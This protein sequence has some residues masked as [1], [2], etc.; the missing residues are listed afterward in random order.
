MPHIKHFQTLADIRNNYAFL[1]RFEAHQDAMRAEDTAKFER[2]CS[3]E[4][5]KLRFDA[6]LTPEQAFAQARQ[7]SAVFDYLLSVENHLARG[8][9]DA[10]RPDADY[11]IAVFQLWIDRLRD[12]TGAPD[13]RTLARDPFFKKQYEACKH[14][15]FQF[16]L[17]GWVNKMPASVPTYASKHNKQ[18][19]TP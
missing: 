8:E 12:I 14:Y 1:L 15:R 19:E 2:L 18:E 16:S 9:N 13:E 5:D 17:P 4:L 6:N 3:Y 10:V 11:A 7:E